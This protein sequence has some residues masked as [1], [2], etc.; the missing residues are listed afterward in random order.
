MEPFGLFQ[1][2]QS[3]LSSAPQT[4][5]PTPPTE[6]P[7][8]EEPALPDAPPAP[9]KKEEIDYSRQAIMGFLSEHD[10]RAGRIK[11]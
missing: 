11:K 8:A 9:E 7:L 10:R 4:E 1:L 2:L 3:F 6:T 5:Q